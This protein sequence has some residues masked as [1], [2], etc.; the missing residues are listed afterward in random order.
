VIPAPTR[1]AAAWSPHVLKHTDSDISSRDTPP[2]SQHNT[3]RDSNSSQHVTWASSTTAGSQ[4]DNNNI[5]HD[6][7]DNRTED[8]ETPRQGP[9]L[10]T[11]LAA[12]DSPSSAEDTAPVRHDDDRQETPKPT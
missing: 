9:V 3:A 11:A 2:D 10:G 1:G 6:E 8:N 12:R 4:G 7:V 5:V